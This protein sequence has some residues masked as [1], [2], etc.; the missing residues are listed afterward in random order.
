[1]LGRDAQR[2]LREG[3]VGAA[4]SHEQLADVARQWGAQQL[5]DDAGQPPR[6][7]ERRRDRSTTDARRLDRGDRTLGNDVDRPVEPALQCLRERDC[8]VALVDQRERKVGE[9]A[10]G[11]DRQAQQAAEGAGDV[12]TDDR[13]APQ[14]G[15]GGIRDRPDLA[16]RVLGFEQRATEAGGGRRN[17]RLIRPRRCAAAASVDLDP[18]P[19]DDAIEALA[20]G[21]GTEGAD[22]EG[23]RQ[24]T[25]EPR[26]TPRVRLVHAE[27]HDGGRLEVADD[28]HQL[29]PVTG[30]DAPELGAVDPTAGRIDVDTEDLLDALIRFEDVGHARADGRAHAGDEDPHCC[31]GRNVGNKIT[32]RMVG[33]S[34]SSMT[35][36]SMPI[37]SPPLGGKPY[38][39]ART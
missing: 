11:H 17:D 33:A 19:D 8:R 38:S 29:A 27:M 35:S 2:L 32:S 25:S 1:M 6:R 3:P 36:R 16:R 28:A 39:R 7:S 30:I 10:D 37:P 34:A 23:V 31:S 5:G 13:R 21:R 12:R 4:T 24:L 15:D 14:C 26:S 20:L 22:R 9:R 18:G